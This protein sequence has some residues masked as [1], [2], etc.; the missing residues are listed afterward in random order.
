MITFGDLFAGG[1]GTSTGAMMLPNVKV[2]WAVN[3]SDIAIQTHARNHP[4][5]IHYRENV[6]NLDVRKLSKVNVLW[7]SLECTNFSIARG[8]IPL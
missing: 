5:T 2:D 6:R 4:K 8:R 3:H 1:G 7:A